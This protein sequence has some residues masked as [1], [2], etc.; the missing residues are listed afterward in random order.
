MLFRSEGLGILKM[1]AFSCT[2]LATSLLGHPLIKAPYQLFQ[3]SAALVPTLFYNNKDFVVLS[4]QEKEKLKRIEKMVDEI[5]LDLGIS[6]MKTNLYVLKELDDNA[7]CMGSAFSLTGA[8]IGIGRSYINHSPFKAANLSSED[9]KLIAIIHSLSDTPET[10][11][12]EID[13]LSLK[14]QKSI[15]SL[16]QD[17]NNYLLTTDE[18]QGV[19]AHELGHAKHAHLMTNFA[20]SPLLMEGVFALF[21]MIEEQLGQQGS[22][23]VKS[24]LFG[25][26]VLSA[27]W[28]IDQIA[29]ICEWQ[30][31]YECQNNVKYAAGMHKLAKRLLIESLLQRDKKK[32]PTCDSKV[33]QMLQS[34]DSFS[35]HPN[36]AKRMKNAL[37]MTANPSP[38]PPQIS[39]TAKMIIGVS[40]V[41]FGMRTINETYGALKYCGSWI[42]QLSA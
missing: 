15:L 41:L 11:A 10:L 14:E 34:W 25:V 12:K 26:K 1:S 31:D 5:K 20:L 35:S 42:W 4:Y 36:L 28:G 22:L 16:I 27:M 39:L 21:K 30:A 9:K 3:L 6:S 40:I 37:E 7:F 33:S 19:I 32:F 23:P 13:A 18:I 38:K 29:R 24:F 8:I 17:E 2:T